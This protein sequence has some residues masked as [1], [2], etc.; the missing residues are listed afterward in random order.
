VVSSSVLSAAMHEVLFYLGH[1]Y[2]LHTRWG[3]LTLNHRLHHASPTNSAI[4]AMYMA[5][6]DFLLEIVVPYLGALWLPMAAGVCSKGMA[7]AT[8]PLGS[9]G[10][11]Y[12]HS[13]YNFLRGVAGLD[14]GVHAAH[15]AR[16][17]CS[18]ADGVGAPSVLDPLLG[19]ACGGG[20]PAAVVIR[21]AAVS[22][23]SS[24]SSS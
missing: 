11:L 8:L 6:V 5:P 13:G 17:D 3:Y 24:S 10:G 12:E 20:G 15:H 7:V 9:V 16:R 23:S 22:S 4:S 21:A 18:F 2:V 14:T 1:R 19:T